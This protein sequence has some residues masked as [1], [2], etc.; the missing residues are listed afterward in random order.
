MARN[1]PNQVAGESLPPGLDD[2]DNETL[3]DTT[4]DGATDGDTQDDTDPAEQDEQNDTTGG[5]TAGDGDEKP[6]DPRTDPNLPPDAS[7]DPATVPRGS[8][9]RTRAFQERTTEPDGIIIRA[10]EPVQVEG[11][12]V[13][14]GVIPDRD[15]YREV[16]PRRSKR[17]TYVLLYRAGA[18]IPRSLLV[19]Q[20]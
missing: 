10:G 9:G 2:N 3:V 13:N 14:G 4:S 6:S 1:R 12:E 11:H 8:A 20:S 18:T 7:D 5:D 16:F 19:K 17:P 15:V